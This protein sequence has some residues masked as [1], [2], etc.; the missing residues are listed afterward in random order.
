MK[1]GSIVKMKLRPA[2]MFDRNVAY[3]KAMLA[4]YK[5]TGEQGCAPEIFEE[6]WAK[7]RIQW[8]SLPMHVTA[9]G[10][11]LLSIEDG[12]LIADAIGSTAAYDSLFAKKNEKGEVVGSA[13]AESAKNSHSGEKQLVSTPTS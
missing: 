1:D 6:E 8:W 9:G 7:C 5:E 11:R 10:W 3:R 4:F 12:P 2:T 13:E